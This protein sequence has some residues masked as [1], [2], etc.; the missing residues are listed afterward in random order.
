[1]KLITVEMFAWRIHRAKKNLPRHR[2]YLDELL[3]L[4]MKMTPN[5]RKSIIINRGY[6]EP[7]YITYVRTKD[8]DVLI[9]MCRDAVG[10]NNV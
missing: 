3:E 10:G 6:G 2:E 9:Q 1:M 8:R 4:Y 5:Q 7:Y